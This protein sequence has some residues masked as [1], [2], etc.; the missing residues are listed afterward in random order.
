VV[1]ASLEAHLGRAVWDRLDLLLVHG[2]HVL[3]VERPTEIDDFHL[4]IGPRPGR[5][6]YVVGLEVGV[7]DPENLQTGQALVRVGHERGQPTE[8][9]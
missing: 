5:E 9:T 8:R 4:N 3:H 7:H 1:Q 6:H 2:V